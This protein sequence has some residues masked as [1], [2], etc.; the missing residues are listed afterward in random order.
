MLHTGCVV[1][2]VVWR[3]AHALCEGAGARRWVLLR[4]GAPHATVGQLAPQ[5]LRGGGPARVKG[6]RRSR[7]PLAGLG[8]VRSYAVS[9]CLAAS[10]RGRLEIIAT[11]P[12]L[13][14]VLV[15]LLINTSRGRLP[16]RGL[17][18]DARHGSSLVQLLLKLSLQ[19]LLMGVLLLFIVTEELEPS[20][21]QAGL[22]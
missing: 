19:R 18:R 14:K 10:V 2:N 4:C 9:S 20:V 22:R 3:V 13:L 7:P 8:N 12:L 6:G 11:L 1:R 5:P 17:T 15:L 16:R 21:G